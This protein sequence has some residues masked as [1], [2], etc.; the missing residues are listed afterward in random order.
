M[1]ANDNASAARHRRQMLIWL[2]V[3][4]GLGLAWRIGRFALRFPI[5]G[6]EAVVLCGVLERGYVALFSE[7]PQYFQVAPLLFWWV[8][9]LAYEWLGAS[10]PA[11]RMFSLLAGCAALLIVARLAWVWL[12]PRAAAM[13]V[14]VFAAGYSLV[15]CANEAKPYAGDALAAA[16]ILWAALRW[17]GRPEG[18]SRAA[19]FG[20]VAAAC[21]WLSFPAVLVGGGVAAAL[22]FWL[23]RRQ[24]PWLIACAAGLALSTATF[25]FTYARDQAQRSAGSWLEEY[26]SEGFPRLSDPLGVLGWLVRAHTSEMLAYPI[27]GRDFGSVIPLLLVILGAVL[28]WRRGQRGLVLVL[29]SPFV[30]GMIAA[31]LHRYPYGVHARL[32]QYLAPMICLL[33]G[34]GGAGALAAIRRPRLRD[35][36]TGLVGLLLLAIPVVGLA[37]DIVQPYKE[38]EGVLL[39]DLV[40]ELRAQLPRGAAVAIL[41]PLE[42]GEEP[43]HAPGFSVV[44]RYYLMA[45]GFDLLWCEE[46]PIP[47]ATPLVIVN[48]GA[49]QPPSREEVERRLARDGMRIVAE[50]QRMCEP[51]R[52]R[53]MFLYHC[54]PDPGMKAGAREP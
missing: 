53:Y 31:L 6:D 8:E 1:S 35:A 48:R 44:M 15:R 34:A 47:P 5:W 51:V 21:V 45:V 14:G 7:P 11:L 26:W 40:R 43:D 28:L 22:L 49:H 38:S 10:E 52:G 42:W 25:Y 13:A 54:E 19:L 9:R 33:V 29:L 27:G 17:A 12:E 30:M 36:I 4:L 46:Q 41:N 23:P 18:W 39:R 20:G 2:L 50:Q 37:R 32:A 16:L 3:F 24:W